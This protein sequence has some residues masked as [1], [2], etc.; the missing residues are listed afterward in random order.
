VEKSCFWIFPRSGFFHGPCD[1]ASIQIRRK[2]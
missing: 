2:Q 1:G